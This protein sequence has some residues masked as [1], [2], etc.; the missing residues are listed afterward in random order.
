MKLQIK[1]AGKWIKNNPIEAL[2]IAVQFGL[3]FLPIWI[4]IFLGAFAGYQLEKKEFIGNLLIYIIVTSATALTNSAGES[5][6]ISQGIHSVA[7]E[8]ILQILF[9]IVLLFSSIFYC[10]LLLDK[11]QLTSFSQIITDIFIGVFILLIGINTFK[12]QV[13]GNKFE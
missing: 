2:R 11:L 10:L 12:N 1:N 4:P 3:Q 6:K 9:P 7:L 8:K 5:R 13:G